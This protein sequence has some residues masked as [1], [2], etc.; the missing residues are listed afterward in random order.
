M[1]QIRRSMPK[2]WQIPRKASPYITVARSSYPKSFSIALAICARDLLK[3]TQNATESKKIIRDGEIEVNGRVVKDEKFGVGLL[4]I[5][6]LKKLKKSYIMILTDK[7]DL[8]LKETKEDSFKIS[9]VIGKKVLNKNAMQVNLFGGKNLIT[10]EKYN[11][12]DSLVIDLKKNQV[13]KVLPLKKDAHVFILSGKWRGN[14]AKIEDIKEDFAEIKVK[15][16]STR[17]PIK[18]TIVVEKEKW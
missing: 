2:T 1:H 6:H 13:L 15:D 3:L 14:I 7:N 8:A 11:I 5:V 18:N 12:N 10:K 17:V 9:K 4:D 16:H